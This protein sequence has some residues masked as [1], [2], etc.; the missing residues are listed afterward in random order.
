MTYQLKIPSYLHV[1]RSIFTLAL[2]FSYPAYS[3]QE[4]LVFALD[5]IRHGARTANDDLPTAPHTWEEGKGQLTATGMQQA[6]QLGLK[7]NQRYQHD[8]LLL[9]QTYQGNT[10]YIRAT[11]YDRTLMS[12]QSVLLGLYPPGT[13]PVLSDAS[14]A[15]PAKI[16]P[17]PI[18]TIP[19]TQDK[20]FLIDIGSDELSQLLEH[21]VYSQA[22]WKEKSK[23]LAP[24]YSRWSQL[25][26]LQI[27]HLFDVLNLG[28]TLHAYL[29][30]DIALPPGLSKDEANTIITASN[31]IAASLFKPQPIGDATGSLALR[32]IND[33]LQKAA[34]GTSKIKFVLISAHDVTTLAVMSALHVPLDF[35]PT[36]AS[37]LNFSLY[38]TSSDDYLVKVTYNDMP[39]NIPGCKGNICPL[40]QFV[41]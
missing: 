26:G 20:A 12:A 34:S 29:A 3:E 2:F 11:D 32:K 13:G 5:L 28:D 24:F 8:N 9:P 15:L 10:I 6:Y 21:H 30:H 1:A 41:K 19:A 27:E 4:T 18:H 38:K 16:Q 17:I 39:I 25:T 35:A 36:Y 31:W 22:E 37:D 14:P 40:N 33:Y 23:D 7:L